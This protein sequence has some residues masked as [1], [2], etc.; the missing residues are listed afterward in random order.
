MHLVSRIKTSFQKHD[1]IGF[2]TIGG[3][4]SLIN[5]AM[6]AL[7][8][9]IGLSSYLAVAIGNLIA[10][11]LYFSGLSKLFSG[12]GSASSFVR[13][14]FTVTAYYF[15]SIA[16]LDALKIF[17]DNLVWRRTIAIALA[18]P[19]NYFAQKYFVFRK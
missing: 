18:A 5:I 15:A 9:E 14:L 10:M 8:I 11:F 17:I 6:F 2:L 1:L 4:T 3:I 19:I 7:C 13:F 12:P 16:L